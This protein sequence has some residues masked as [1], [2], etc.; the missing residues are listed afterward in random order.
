MRA[1]APFSW[2]ILLAGIITIGVAVYMVAVSYSSLPWD[3]GWIQVEPL[4]NGINPYSLHW[5]WAQH[6]DHRLVFTKLFLLADL[7]LF[8]A[9]QWFLLT[10]ILV[11]QLLFCAVLSW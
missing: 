9:R 4:V 3:D 10:S 5:I 8:H 7:R 6:D 11:L 1:S 2:A